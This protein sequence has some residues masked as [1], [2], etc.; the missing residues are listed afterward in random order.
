MAGMPKLETDE[1]ARK[2]ILEIVI[3]FFMILA[4]NVADYFRQADD[5]NWPGQAWPHK[6]RGKTWIFFLD[7]FP[8]DGWHWCQTISR[9]GLIF[10]N[11]I[12]T[13]QSTWYYT[14]LLIVAVNAVARGLGFS[15]LRRFFYGRSS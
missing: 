4:S 12:I 13:L 11:Y 14:I 7:W 10:G 3:A 6:K 1:G 9:W 5:H 8:H 15:L 2:M